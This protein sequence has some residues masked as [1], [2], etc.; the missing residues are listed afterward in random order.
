MKVFEKLKSSV[1]PQAEEAV[2]RLKS[3]VIPQAEEAKRVLVRL[4]SSVMEY[5]EQVPQ[6][7]DLHD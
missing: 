6:S 3:S 7:S 4:K 2:E 1:K 5:V